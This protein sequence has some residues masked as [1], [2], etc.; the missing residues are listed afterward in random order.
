MTVRPRARRIRSCL[1]PDMSRG[2]P[3]LQGL[4]GQGGFGASCHTFVSVTWHRTRPG[5]TWRRGY[6]RGG[7]PGRAAAGRAAA[8]RADRD[9]RC[10]SAGSR[11]S[12]AGRSRCGCPEATVRRFGSGPAV[13][14]DDPRRR[15]SSGGSRRAGRSAS[16]SRTWP[17]S[18]T[19][20]ISSALFELLLRNASAAAAAAPDAAPDLDA[21]P[22]PNRRNGLAPRPP[23]HRL[24]LRP[25]Q[26]ALRA[27][28]RPDD[29][30]L[31]RRLRGRGRAARGRPAAQAPP[32][33]RQAR[34]RPGRPRA[35]DR[36]RLGQLRD[37][38][39]RRSAAAAS[40][41]SRSRRAQATPRPRAGRAR[42]GVE[43]PVEIREEDY[44][45]HR[46]SYTRSPRSRCSRRSARSSSARTSPRST[47]CSSPAAA[48]ACRRSSSPTTAGSATAE[49]PRLDR[50][51]RL[52]RLP[53]PVARRARGR[54]GRHSSSLMIHEV[55]E[56]G[57]SYAETLRRW[58]ESFDAQHRRGARARLRPPL[59]AHLGLLPRLLR[60]GVPHAL[61]PR[62]PAD[63]LP[64]VR[65]MKRPPLYT[66]S[67]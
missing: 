67:R 3:G 14:I 6:E 45:S 8:A 46:G 44:R 54:L 30:L 32:D 43:R 24:P 2:P 65:R 16:A 26:R 41:A 60:G 5:G 47:A 66:S 51:L 33:L 7:A 42:P 28:A 56:I 12:R 19:P 17:A 35:R 63:P 21:P 10:S 53:D 52:P 59:R 29:D 18:G 31:V 20:T 27:D 36:L 4:L 57:P 50:A 9:R 11:T 1:A 15:G 39:R 64:L 38:R 62:R 55:E 58:R 23:Q 25:R 40:P 61:A 37:P 49:E 22:R 13:A 48:P 34:A